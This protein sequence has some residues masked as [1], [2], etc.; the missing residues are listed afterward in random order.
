MK[1]FPE[2][3]LFLFYASRTHSTDSPRQG[4]SFQQEGSEQ[5]ALAHT[6]RSLTHTNAC[7]HRINR[8]ARA[9][10][11][12]RSAVTSAATREPARGLAAAGARGTWYRLRASKWTGAHTPCI[13]TGDTIWA[14][15]CALTG[16]MAPLLDMPLASIFGSV[17]DENMVIKSRDRNNPYE[18]KGMAFLPAPLPPYPRPLAAPGPWPFWLVHHPSGHHPS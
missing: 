15:A 7:M 1:I 12:L 6:L 11:V 8:D 16:S 2:T 4:K 10:R 18:A 9:C 13:A 5:C 14:H 17:N 3:A